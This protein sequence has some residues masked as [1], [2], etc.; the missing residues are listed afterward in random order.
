MITSITFTLGTTETYYTKQTPTLELVQKIIQKLCP[1]L[2]C[3]IHK[4]ECSE[5]VE[6]EGQIIAE[7][8]DGWPLECEH[9]ML[10]LNT[11]EELEI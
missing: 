11:I 2:S 10:T 8:Q 4:D 3:R 5:W 6:V 7:K 9:P 1:A